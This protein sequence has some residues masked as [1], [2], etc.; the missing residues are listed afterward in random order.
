MQT[1]SPTHS[2]SAFRPSADGPIR[3]APMFIL[4]TLELLR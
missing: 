3:D 4:E 2:W 1:I